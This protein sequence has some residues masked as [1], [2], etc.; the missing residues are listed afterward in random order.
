MALWSR[1]VNTTISDYLR[2]TEPAILRNRKLTAMLQKKGRVTFN[3]SGTDMHWKV[4]YRRI[5]IEQISDM[6]I[7]TFG[8][9]DRWKSA[10]IDWRGY[11]VTDAISKLETLVNRGTEA[12]VKFTQGAAER[13]IED[14]SEQF[15]EE[16]YVDGYATGNT[17]RIHGLNS[18]FRGTSPSSAGKI[19]TPAESYAGLSTVLGNYGGSWAGDWPYGAGDTSYDFWSPIYIDYTD[20][21]WAAATDTWSTNAVEC[22]RYGIIA[23]Q[24]NNSKSGM[25]DM[26]LTSQGMYRDFLDSLD[27]KE[28]INVMRSEKDSAMIALGFKDVVIFDGMEI[29]SEYGLPLDAT[30]SRDVAY[31]L[32]FDKMELCSLQ[33]R[34]FKYDGPV[35]ETRQQVYLH[36]VDFM[37]NLKLASPR[38]FVKFVGQT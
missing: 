38:Y 8:R 28:R 16:L 3:H 7:G 26:V 21:A 32:N 36:S 1:V 12:I 13:L 27:E 18:I 9:T 34:L 22:L 33:D 35:W 4:E 11:R 15:A 24:R 29:T 37:G 2:T 30:N 6:D 10:S 23:A 20:T 25:L 14:I 17:K 31:G 19:V 5:P